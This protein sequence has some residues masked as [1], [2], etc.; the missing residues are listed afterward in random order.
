[1]IAVALMGLSR[2]LALLTAAMAIV[3]VLGATAVA[4]HWAEISRLEDYR[5]ETVELAH[6]LADDLSNLRPPGNPA[7]IARGLAAWSKDRIEETHARAFLFPQGRSGRASLAGASDS[8]FGA[9]TIVFHRAVLLAGATDVTLE[10]GEN[11]A[12]R[13]LVPVHSGTT[14]T[15][16]DAFVST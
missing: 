7:A 1:M 8:A 4:S 3:L 6:T 14:P 11:P 16:L 2:R 5:L 12:W 10:R 9:R 15:L 13:A